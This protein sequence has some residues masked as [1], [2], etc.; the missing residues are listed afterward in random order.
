MV[1]EHHGKVMML[2][3][4][5]SGTRGSREDRLLVQWRASDRD[6]NAKRDPPSCEE[7][8]S[9]PKRVERSYQDR[10]DICSGR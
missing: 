1:R 2:Y 8:R 6:Q 10:L 9:G 3:A 5:G 7:A 4:L